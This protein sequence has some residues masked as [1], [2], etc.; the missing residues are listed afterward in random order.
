MRPSPQHAR[1]SKRFHLDAVLSLVAALGVF[2]FYELH[3]LSERDPWFIFQ[4]SIAAVVFVLSAW[5]ALRA[6]KH[7]G[8]W[9]RRIGLVTLAVL[10]TTLLI[11]TLLSST[12][13]PPKP[14][15]IEYGDP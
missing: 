15:R 4:L 7:S 10:L 9:N 11:A 5:G 3:G 1:R 6:F 12:A 8:R 13:E 2:A 14:Q